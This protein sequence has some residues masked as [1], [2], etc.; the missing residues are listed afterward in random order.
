M[1]VTQDTAKYIIVHKN[2][3]GYLK[4]PNQKI[5]INVVSA[6]VA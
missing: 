4:R 2:L 6:Y 1:A 3:N 5:K